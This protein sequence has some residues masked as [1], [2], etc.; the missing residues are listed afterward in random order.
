MKLQPLN[1]EQ[2]FHEPL[3]EMGIVNKAVNYYWKT[4]T[5]SDVN[6]SWGCS[7]PRDVAERLF[8]PLV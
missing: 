5:N 1:L 4:V 8:P 2:I 7:M 6:T 3:A